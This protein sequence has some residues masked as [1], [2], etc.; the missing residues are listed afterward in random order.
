MQLTRLIDGKE[1]HALGIRFCR[2]Y[3]LRLEKRG[4]FPERIR[5]GQ[6]SVAWR[7]DEV[8]AWIETR[9]KARGPQQELVPIGPR[10][11]PR[12]KQI[13]FKVEADQ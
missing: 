3:L 12:K 6:N 2:A 13:D 4:Q 5:L 11:R 10:G 9:S 8:Q 1:L 7:L